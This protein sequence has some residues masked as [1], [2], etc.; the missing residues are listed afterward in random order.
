MAKGPKKTIISRIDR[1][2]KA[3]AP[4]GKKKLSDRAAALKSGLSADGI[5][6]LRRQLDSGRQ[7][8]VRTDTLE[9]LAIGLGTTTQWLLKEEGPEFIYEPGHLESGDILRDHDDA[10]KTVRVAGYVGASGEAVYYRFSDDQFEYVEPPPGATD[11]TVAVEVRGGSLGD[12]FKSWLVFYRDIRSPVT[13]DLYGRLCVVGLADDRIL[14]KIIKHEPD[15]SF[16]LLSNANIEPPI[17]QAEVE[18]ASRVTDM[19]PR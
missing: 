4:P 18:W 12:A 2:L 6:T 14:V 13:E 8:G 15:G 11:Q 9:K 10:K 16:T 1:R 5:R 3:L 7:I 19:R 17:K